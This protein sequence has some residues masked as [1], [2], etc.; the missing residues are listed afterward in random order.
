V[1]VVG[2]VCGDGAD[3]AVAEPCATG[4]GPREALLAGGRQPLGQFRDL[5]VGCFV[6]LLCARAHAATFVAVD[7]GERIGLPRANDAGEVQGD[8]D[9]HAHDDQRDEPDG[10]SAA[11]G[12]LGIVLGKGWHGFL[13]SADVVAGDEQ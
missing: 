1:V 2:G 11:A 9:E 10:W 7:W 8:C 6:Q 4:A 5:A 12:G 3:G 13:L